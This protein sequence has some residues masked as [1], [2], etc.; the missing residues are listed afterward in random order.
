LN[1]INKIS[2]FSLN[3]FI[4][5]FHSITFILFILVLTILTPNLQPVWQQRIW[6]EEE[7][8]FIGVWE[9]DGGVEIQKDG[10]SKCLKWE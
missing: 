7:N 1:L 3:Q 9:E 10:G 4:T 8:G 6:H 2:P 5:C